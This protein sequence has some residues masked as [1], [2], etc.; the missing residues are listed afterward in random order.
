MEQPALAEDRHDR[1]LGGDRA[2]AGSGRPRRVFERWR[3][4][5]NAAS[6][7]VCQ[8]IAAGGLE[9]L[10]VLGVRAR[11]AALDVGH[12]VLVE[13]PGDPE[14]VGEAEGDVLAL[15]AVA[16]G[17][18]V[19]GDGAVGRCVIGGAPVVRWR[20]TGSR[21]GCGGCPR[22]LGNRDP[23]DDRRRSSPVVPTRRSP[24]RRRPAARGRPSGSRRRG[25]R[26]TAAS[27]AAAASSRPS[28][29]R[30]SIAADRIVPIGLARSRPAMS[31]AEPWIG[32]YRPNVPCSVRRSPSDADGS[33]PRLPARTAASSDRMSPNRF[34]VTITSKSA[35]RRTS[36]I[37]HES[38][39]W[40][41][42]AT[43]GC[44]APTS[45]ATRPPQ[46]RRGED[47]GLVDARHV[48]AP[49]AASSNASSTTRRISG[50]VYG[51]VSTARRAR[52]ARRLGSSRSPK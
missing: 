51:S 15:G 13:H 3:V 26:L 39:S 43:S 7:A 44:S 42:S 16:E 5:P 32:S 47:V 21:G 22:S 41:S 35:G 46:A 34:S 4:D 48:A 40:W 14:L 38:T 52:P 8:V 9:E 29:S 50:S 36:S 20:S 25:R 30:R 11:P 18:V 31:G 45:S 28:D 1:R 10:D 2:R 6:F 12:A 24:R 33:I 23:L 27:I 19:E 37:A 49:A 17:R